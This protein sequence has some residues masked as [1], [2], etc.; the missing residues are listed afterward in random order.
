MYIK[1][2]I[3]FY[4]KSYIKFYIKCYIRFY[5]KIYA[6]PLGP[7]PATTPRE[8]HDFFEKHLSFDFFEK[9]VFFRDKRENCPFIWSNLFFN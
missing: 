5:I 4:I 9:V 8:R 7:A 6:R 1:H 2:Y 3:K